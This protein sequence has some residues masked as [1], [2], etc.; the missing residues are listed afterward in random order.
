LTAFKNAESQFIC[1]LKDGSFPAPVL[2]YKS[3]TP[4]KVL[5]LARSVKIR[6]REKGR[7]L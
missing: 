6:L 4:N 1:H 2:I 3:N 7:L 5:N